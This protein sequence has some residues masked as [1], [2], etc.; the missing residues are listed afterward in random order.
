MQTATYIL[1]TLPKEARNSWLAEKNRLFFR[2]NGQPVSPVEGTST[3]ESG[4]QL[5]FVRYGGKLFY[6]PQ[7]EITQPVGPPSNV[8]LRRWHMLFR[9]ENVAGIEAINAAF[10]ADVDAMRAAYEKSPF[11]KK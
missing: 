8:W 9:C 7:G 3:L 4:F 11:Y 5:Q 1:N 2:S 6:N 10:K